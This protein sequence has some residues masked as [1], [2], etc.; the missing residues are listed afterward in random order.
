MQ[1]LLGQAAQW[2]GMQN[3]YAS[4]QGKTIMERLQFKKTSLELQVK[5]ASDEL[6]AVNEAI[7]KL[8]ADPNLDSLLSLLGKSGVIIKDYGNDRNIGL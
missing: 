5:K 1:G 3:A 8:K 6:E 7:G 2:A 4:P